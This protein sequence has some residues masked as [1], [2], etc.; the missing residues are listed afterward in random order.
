[1]QFGPGPQGKKQTTCVLVA[2]ALLITKELNLLEGYLNGSL[3]RPETVRLWPRYWV[4]ISG[5]WLDFHT[6]D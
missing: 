1:M 4:L 2:K 5:S 3:S 6:M